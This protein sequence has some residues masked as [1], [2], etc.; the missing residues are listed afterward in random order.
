MSALGPAVAGVLS[1]AVAIALF[2]R[3]ILEVRDRSDARIER[4]A[5]GAYLDSEVVIA[6]FVRGRP[7]A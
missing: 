5:G 4:D 1:G 7:E 6:H 2:R 3:R